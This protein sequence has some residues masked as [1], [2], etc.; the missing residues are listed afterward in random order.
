MNKNGKTEDKENIC[1]EEFAKMAGFPLD[2]VKKELF[3]NEEQ[4][5][6]L[7]LSELREAMLGY[8]SS[9][10]MEEELPSLS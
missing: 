3:E 5:K 1:L 6:D 8:L 2:L 7:S 9:T 4:P 10:M